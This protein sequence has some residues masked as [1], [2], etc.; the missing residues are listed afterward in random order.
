MV[1]AHAY[2]S[3]AATSSCPGTNK[4]IFESKTAL[5]TFERPAANDA[6]YFFFFIR[7]GWCVCPDNLVLRAAIRTVE[8]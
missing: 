6:S 4:E 8:E 5:A 1:Q 3:L 7:D 2:L